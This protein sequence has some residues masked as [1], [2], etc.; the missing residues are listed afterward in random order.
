MER[1]AFGKKKLGRRTMDRGE[2]A[3]PCAEE[4]GGDHHRQPMT[5]SILFPGRRNLLVD[6]SQERKGESPISA[7]SRKEGGMKG[8]RREGQEGGAEEKGL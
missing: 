4:K 6:F 1:Y 8:G 7:P 3:T 5:G 2:V